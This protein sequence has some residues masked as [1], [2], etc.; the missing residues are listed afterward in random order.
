MLDFVAR[1][2]VAAPGH[3][4]C[5]HPRWTAYVGQRRDTFDVAPWNLYNVLWRFGQW[6]IRRA[7][8]QA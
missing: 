6:A 3:G 8:P 7:D 4:L 5:C 2:V 1:L